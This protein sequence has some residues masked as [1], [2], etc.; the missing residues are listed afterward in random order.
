MDR[1]SLLRLITPLIFVCLLV[2]PA[3]AQQPAFA[4]L[5]Q[6]AEAALAANDIDKAITLYEKLANFYPNSSVAQNRLGFA[7]FKKGNDPRAIYCFR[8]A[9]SLSRDNDEA[10][11]NLILAGGRQADTLAREARFAEAAKSLDELIAHY[12][13]HPQAAALLYYR[14]RVEFLRGKPEDGLNWWKKAAKAAPTSGVA[15][16]VLAQTLPMGEKAVNLYYE[17]AKK[18]PTEPAFDY[19]LGH[20]YLE[21]QD[22]EQALKSFDRGLSKCRETDIPFPL[23]GLKAAQAALSLQQTDKAVKL[24]EEAKLQ[25]PDWASIRTNLWAA[26]LLAGDPGLADSALQDAFELDGRPKLAVLSQEKSRVELT[27]SGGSLELT[28]VSAVSPSV[29]PAAL[30]IPG[31]AKIDFQVKAGD[32]IVYETDGKTLTLVS[33]AQLSRQTP[34]EGSL[35]PALV[36]K[37]RRGSLYRMSDALLKRPIVILFWSSQD[38]GPKELLDGLGA[39]DAR[40]K[41]SVETVAVHVDPKSQK[42]ALRLYLSQPGTSAQLWGEASSPQDFGLKGHPCVAVVDRSGR[43]VMRVDAPTTTTFKD[44][45]WFLDDLPPAP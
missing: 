7:H 19:L 27:T 37:D 40:Y 29:G 36:A 4:E 18:V 33:R 45:P 32:A 39:I 41:G 3:L 9:L 5:F 13:W 10:L 22:T 34:Q 35:A 38:A 25:R 11:H 24:L 6:R 30:A 12:S 20:R 31:G 23:L 1:F 28:P 16:V 43:I 21:I 17:A 14:G 26:Y 44:L 2:P 42:D 15:K 8:K